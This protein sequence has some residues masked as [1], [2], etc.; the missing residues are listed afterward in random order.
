MAFPLGTADDTNSS[1]FYVYNSDIAYV[2]DDSGKLHKFTGLF[3]GTP[4]EVVGGG[5]PAT[6]SSALLS[7]A[8]YDSVTGNVFVEDSSGFLYSVNASGVATQSARLDFGAGLRE[9]PIVDSSLGEVYVFS[10]DDA[11][12]GGSAGVFQVST[13]LTAGATGRE[14]LIGTATSGGATP[15]Y[16][17]GFDNNYV[18]SADR[19]GN[20]YVCG[21]PGQR[22]TL[23]QVSVVAGVITTA[24]PGPVVGT[25]SETPCSPVT[26]IYNPNVTGAGL[27][28]ERV[29]FSVQGAGSPAG[30]LTVSC[31]M[32][33][34]VT[35]WTP[36]TVYN[37]GQEVLDSNL[38]IEVAENSGGT[39]GATTPA[40]GSNKFDP[41]ID[42]GVHWRNQGPLSGQTPPQW[43]ANNA[44]AGAFEI[45]DSNNNI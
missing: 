35:Q 32:S 11:A 45:V 37:R 38:N 21:N 26:D 43:T 3:K 20:L 8:V 14:V 7:S 44:Y 4:A 34:K 29:F 25:A 9:G 12:I 24:T 10:S 31:V 41:T 5:W 19:T 28:Q 40:W 27:P 36:A 13:S 33:F 2:G 42:G 30:C 39:S 1:V 15:V 6:V 16:T 18:S 17:G 23:Y 22:P